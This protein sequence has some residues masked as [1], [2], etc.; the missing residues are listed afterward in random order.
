MKKG[1]PVS[2]GVAVAHAYCVDEVLAR[3]EPSQLDVAALSGEINRFDRAC[4][5]AAEEL[6][7]IVARVSR[8]VGEEEAAIFRAHRL[9]LRDPALVGKVKTAIL[10]RHVDAAAALHDA[11]DEYTTLFSKIEDEYL[12]ERMSDLRDIVSRIM[13]QLA[14]QKCD[15]PLNVG[16]PVILVAPEILPSQA[17]S[18]DRLHVAGIITETGGATGHAAILARSLGIPAVSGMR[19]ILREV[20]TG[21]LVALDGRE[22]F[23]HLNPG[24][25]VEAAYRKLQREYVN[26]RDRLIKNSDQEPVTLDGMHVELLANVNGPEDAAMAARVGASAVGLYRT[27]FL[28]LTHPTVPNE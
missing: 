11:L 2:P 20:H 25:E 7:A 21:D 12:K 23:V 16:E 22:G 24:P 9:L 28:F 4:A 8:Q 3:R 15:E 19:G 14:L 26:L 1:V 10:N 13:A 27:E 5:A 18:F 17:L 6:D